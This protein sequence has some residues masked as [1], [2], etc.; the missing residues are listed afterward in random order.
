[1]APSL[2]ACLDARLLKKRKLLR[3]AGGF[4]VSSAKP[5]SAARHRGTL[6]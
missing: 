6:P 5:V 4:R 3:E 2:L 1:M